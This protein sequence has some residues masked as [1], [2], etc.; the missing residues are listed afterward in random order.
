MRLVSASSSRSRS[1]ASASGARCRG[2]GTREQ[3]NKGTDRLLVLVSL[4]LVLCSLFFRPLGS[5]FF[6]RLTSSQNRVQSY[7]AIAK[8]HRYPSLFGAAVVICRDSLT[9]RRMPVM[10]SSFDGKPPN[11]GLVQSESGVPLGVMDVCC[12]TNR[13]T[14]LQG[15]VL[16]IRQRRGRAPGSMRLH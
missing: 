15:S 3:G 8:S 2:K 11:R 1:A 9:R 6:V 5:W 14:C 16:H 12:T 4:F 10:T 7:I 13:F